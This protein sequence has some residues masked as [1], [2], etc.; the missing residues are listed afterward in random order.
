LKWGAQDRRIDYISI[1]LIDHS[2]VI[3]RP[4]CSL[5]KH[6][7]K[8]LEI[9]LSSLI[10]V[11]NDRDLSD[12][13]R[14]GKKI[15]KLIKATK[16]PFIFTMGAKSNLEL[17]TGSQMRL[18]GGLLDVPYHNTKFCVFEKQFNILLNNLAKLDQSHIF[19]GIRE[20]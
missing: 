13:L 16:T 11:K 17:R 9:I 15:M 6:N 5:I 18:L 10:N 14:K 1:D 4:F 7:N 20:V 2:K 8:T 19:E 3:D 12:V